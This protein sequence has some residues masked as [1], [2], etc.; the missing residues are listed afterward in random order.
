MGNHDLAQIG[1]ALEAYETANN[2]W[3]GTR[4][5]CSIPEHMYSLPPE[6]VKGGYLTGLKKTNKTYVSNIDDKFYVGHTYKYISPG[7]LF[8]NTGMPYFE[9]QSIFISKNFPADTSGELV[10]YTDRKKSPVKWV[11][12]SLGPGYDAKKITSRNWTG[13]PIAEG[14]PISKDSWYGRKKAGVGIL[15]RIKTS[16]NQFYGTFQKSK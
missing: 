16:N 10:K 9:E 3:P 8:N 15:T 11:I 2:S 1:L 7:P 13:F 14:F 6:L 4:M 5:D 12:F